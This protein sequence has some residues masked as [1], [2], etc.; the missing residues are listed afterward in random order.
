MRAGTLALSLLL[1]CLTA[2]GE[3]LRVPVSRRSVSTLAT[4]LPAPAF[5]EACMGKCADPDAERKAAE[6]R[7]IQM[8]S[9]SGKP[10]SFASMVEKA[11]AQ[12]EAALGMSMSDSEKKALEV[13]MR[14]AYPGVQ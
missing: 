4:L 14:A 9:S 6:R 10:D 11:V 12:R 8:G 1:I 5:A 13:R 3:A 7:A 2:P